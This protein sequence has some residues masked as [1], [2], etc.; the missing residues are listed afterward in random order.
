ML[1][2]SG[3]LWAALLSGRL[4]RGIDASCY[5]LFLNEF[6]ENLIRGTFVNVWAADLNFGYGDP[7]LLFRQPLLTYLHEIIFLLTRRYF[8]A[9]NLCNVVTLALA[10]WGMYSLARALLATLFR[11]HPDVHPWGP[12]TASVGYLLSPYLLYDLYIRGAYSE[13]LC[14]AVLPW[15]ALAFLRLAYKPSCRNLSLAALAYFCLSVAHPAI[16]LVAFPF[17]LAAGVLW[18]KEIKDPIPWALPI[19]LGLAASSYYWAPALAERNATKSALIDVDSYSYVHHLYRLDQI[20]PP[21]LGTNVEDYRHF[22]GW[23]FLIGLGLGLWLWSDRGWRAS[24]D[25]RLRKAVLGLL[26]AVAAC[27]YLMHRSSGPW[28]ELVPIL[29]MMSFPSRFLTLT[30][31]FSCLLA[32]LCAGT[33]LRRPWQWLC[34]TALLLV[35]S[36]FDLRRASFSG[37]AEGQF[38]PEAII[39]G[40]W[41][42]IPRYTLPVTVPARP[43]APAPSLVEAVSGAATLDC[44]RSSPTRVECTAEVAQPGALRLNVFD[45]PGWTAFV[46]GKP[47]ARTG[48]D[49]AHGALL[50]FV[51]LPGRHLVR[52]EFQD[53]PVRS[54][55]KF[56]SLAAWLLLAA[57]WF[58]SDVRPTRR[59]R[60]SYRILPQ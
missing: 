55:S 20:L 17:L 14:F 1:A 25:A 33:L 40:G 53:T 39:S 57:L 37:L 4:P 43:T 23:L 49:P 6:H 44:G 47:A 8:A 10:A 27:V 13:S 9:V 22:P 58:L 45:F 7:Y 3:W 18:R 60:F 29:Q 54:A 36:F 30:T 31:F 28:Y 51:D 21:G 26:G 32:V 34:L 12:I 41:G 5:P 24:A 52:W 19:A 56:V 38:A 42:W 48:R 11:E 16:H 15:L 46:D 35:S 59:G 50:V 2:A